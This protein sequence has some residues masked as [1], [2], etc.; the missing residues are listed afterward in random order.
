MMLSLTPRANRG[1]ARETFFYIGG[2]RRAG[3]EGWRSSRSG[4]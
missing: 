1:T 3:N 4:V 2:A